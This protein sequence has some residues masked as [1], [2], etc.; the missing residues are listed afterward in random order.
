M[1]E[2]LRKELK[3]AQD[4]LFSKKEALKLKQE[5]SKRQSALIDEQLRDLLE[6]NR[7]LQMQLSALKEIL[8]SKNEYFV[9]KQSAR[10]LKDSSNIRYDSL[11]NTTKGKDALNATFNSFFERIR[12]MQL[13]ITGVV[14]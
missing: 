9:L 14:S 1:N 10:A 8:T 13:K 11:T 2:S 7:F 12:D 4:E 3:M 6:K 5:Q